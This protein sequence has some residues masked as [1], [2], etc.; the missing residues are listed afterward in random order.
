MEEL[1][2]AIRPIT[3]HGSAD[4]CDTVLDTSENER[5]ERLLQIVFATVLSRES[6]F[7]AYIAVGC[8]MIK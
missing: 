2:N 3:A 5:L 8:G 4:C 1:E 6:G 7:M